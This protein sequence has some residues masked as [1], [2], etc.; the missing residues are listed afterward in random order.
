MQL[1]AF[2]RQQPFKSVSG[3][4]DSQNIDESDFLQTFTLLTA[5][6]ISYTENSFQF[7][8]VC[9][10]IQIYIVSPNNLNN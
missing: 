3:L 4:V 9:R 1:C 5:F 6:Y 7:S 10:R 2:A 8:I